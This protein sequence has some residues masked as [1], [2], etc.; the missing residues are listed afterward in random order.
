MHLPGFPAGRQRPFQKGDLKFLILSQLKDK[1]NYGYEI[2]REL[3]KRFNGFYAPSPGIVYPLC[4][5]WK[6]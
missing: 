3:E 4:R 5:C 2:M 6:K 1:S